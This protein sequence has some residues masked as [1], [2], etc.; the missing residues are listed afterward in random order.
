MLQLSMGFLRFLF[1]S[2]GLLKFPWVFPQVLN[3]FFKVSLG[4]LQVSYRFY[5]V[6]S[7]SLGGSLRFLWLS[8]GSPGF[9]YVSISFRRFPSI[10]FVG[11]IKFPWVF[12]Q[13]PQGS[14]LQPKP[15]RGIR[16][17]ISS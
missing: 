15:L 10:L 4:F 13:V 1:V 7:S 11:F 3:V 16:D 17:C 2:S 5:Q 9:L 6:S 14:A 8:S 12:H